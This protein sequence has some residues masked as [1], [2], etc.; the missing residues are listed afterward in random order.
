MSDRMV[1]Q[2][3]VR[4]VVVSLRHPGATALP[5]SMSGCHVLECFEEKKKKNKKRRRKKEVSQ[6]KKK[7]EEKR[8]E[9]KRKEKK[10]KKQRKR[11]GRK[12]KFC[13]AFKRT[14]C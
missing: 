2:P 3:N 5:K 10:R 4:F 11:E 6:R 1:G 9:K 14:C 12:K 8:R 7:R 13:F